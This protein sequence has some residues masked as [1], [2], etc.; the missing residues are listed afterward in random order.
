MDIV[1]KHLAAALV[2]AAI[3]I[4][5][6]TARA[7]EFESVPPVRHQPTVDECGECHMVYQPMLLSRE[8]WAAIMDDLPNHFGE[9]ASLPAELTAEIRAYLVGASAPDRRSGAPPLLR[10]TEQRWWLHEHDEIRASRWQSPEIG[11]K[12]N[13]VACHKGAERGI[14]DDEDEDDD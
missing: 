5:A 3:V 7:D 2:S 9:D 11:S 10:I 1:M 14:Y 6:G 8:S 13:C 12:G 4:G